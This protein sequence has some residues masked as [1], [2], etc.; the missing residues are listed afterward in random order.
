MINGAHEW[1]NLTSVLGETTITPSEEQ[2]ADALRELFANPDDEHPD[3]WINCGSDDGPLFN[4]SVFSS[5]YAVYTKYSDV[6]MTEEL[7]TLTIPNVDAAAGL[8]LWRNLIAGNP[9]A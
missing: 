2:L 3:A 6:D 5:G 1:V 8:M 7:E 9:P 4:I